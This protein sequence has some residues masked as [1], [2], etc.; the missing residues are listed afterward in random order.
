MRKAIV[1]ISFGLLLIFSIGHA[2]N[3]VKPNN[4]TYNPVLSLF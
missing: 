1:S 3:P 2:E 4:N